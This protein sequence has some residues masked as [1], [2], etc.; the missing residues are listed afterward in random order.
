MN[1]RDRTLNTLF[2]L[3]VCSWGVLGLWHAGAEDRWTVAR[4]G[5]ALL[6]FAAGGLILFRAPVVRDGGMWGVVVAMPSMLAG[7]W[8]MKIM[9]AP[10]TWPMEAN[11]LFA[12]GTLWTLWAFA[13]LGRSFD[14]F[15]SQNV[16]VDGG[17]YALLRHPAYAGEM[18]LIVACFVAHPRWEAVAPLALALPTI[19][20]RIRAEEEILSHDPAYRAYCERVA[21]RLLPGVW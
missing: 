5:I 21:W 14:L 3:S 12:V 11:A 13:T 8:A 18:L 4:V 15:P 16:I 7:A 19:A 17:P 2:G 1:L 9:P 20:W 6:N 10:S